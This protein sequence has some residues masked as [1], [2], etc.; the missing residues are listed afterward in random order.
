MYSSLS[1]VTFSFSVNSDGK[2]FRKA[3]RSDSLICHFL[4]TPLNALVDLLTTTLL[5]CLKGIVA[6]YPYVTI[7]FA[8]PAKFWDAFGFPF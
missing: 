2:V 6:V 4:L 8:D 1:D 3:F 5:V 7:L